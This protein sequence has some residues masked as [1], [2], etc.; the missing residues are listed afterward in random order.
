[1]REEEA[2]EFDETG[3]SNTPNEEGVTAQSQGGEALSSP[4]GV[5]NGVENYGAGESSLETSPASPEGYE[6]ARKMI[7]ERHG[8][9][10]D[11]EDPL[12][13]MVTLLDE[14]R[15]QI[16]KENE[17]TI[18]KLGDVVEKARREL[19]GA[20]EETSR[21]ILDQAVNSNLK[22]TI[23]KLASETQLIEALRHEL[24]KH[25]MWVGILT[26][27]TV[28]TTVMLFISQL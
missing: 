17:A 4:P 10:V 7:M 1:M 23:A 14:Q 20:A 19:V 8:V 15:A 2:F 12:L 5:G 21:V 22:N 28:V 25:K 11:K 6:E 3:D 9:V 24:K 13:I 27:I 26:G 16:H 18:A